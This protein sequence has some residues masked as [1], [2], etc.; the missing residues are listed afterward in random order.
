MVEV[1][2]KS[3]HTIQETAIYIF[4][5][6]PAWVFVAPQKIILQCMSIKCTILVVLQIVD[7]A[8]AA[9]SK[10]INDC[11]YA[12]QIFLNRIAIQTPCFDCNASWA[13]NI[14]CCA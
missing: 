3:I 7:R 4:V 9:A 12:I 1:L 2:V 10:L 8:F 6:L 14:I 5:S 11:K 13:T